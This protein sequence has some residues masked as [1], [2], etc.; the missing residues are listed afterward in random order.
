MQ[1]GPAVMAM[2]C[3]YFFVFFSGGVDWVMNMPASSWP[4]GCPA[5]GSLI[6]L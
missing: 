1:V 2:S 5:F 4:P 3:V 6:V